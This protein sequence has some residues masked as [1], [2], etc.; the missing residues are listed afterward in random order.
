VVDERTL[1]TRDAHA[2]GQ[3]C[4]SGLLRLAAAAISL[5]P[6]ACE[7]AQ[8]I[9]ITA[10]TVVIT[11]QQHRALHQ[12]VAQQGKHNPNCTVRPTV[13]FVTHPYAEE[14]E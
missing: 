8:P 11:V 9:E 4:C 2:P 3:H 6:D 12:S 5:C 1:N 10:A 14:F 7:Q 13:E